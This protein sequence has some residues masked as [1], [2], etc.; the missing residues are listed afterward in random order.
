MSKNN[1]HYEVD[2]DDS[3]GKQLPTLGC[4]ENPCIKVAFIY[5]KAK[6]LLTPVGTTT[7]C[8]TG[9]SVG[10]NATGRSQAQH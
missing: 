7:G 9:L 10:R 5:R 1:V 4:N 3:S 6:L 2:E 8:R